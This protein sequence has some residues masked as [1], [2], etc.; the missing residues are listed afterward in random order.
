[1]YVQGGPNGAPMGHVFSP[2]AGS[3][4][5]PYAAYSPQP[6]PQPAPPSQ[7]QYPGLHPA[8]PPPQQGGTCGPPLVRH[9]AHANSHHRPPPVC[10]QPSTQQQKGRPLPPQHMDA[11]S[12]GMLQQ[13]CSPP[14]SGRPTPLLTIASRYS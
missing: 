6:A 13:R 7:S 1:M 10:G 3:G 2:F 4:G 12:T 14:H 8:A 5:S 9:P 11:Q